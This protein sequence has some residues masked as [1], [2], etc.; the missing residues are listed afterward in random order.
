[1]KVCFKREDT[2]K[3]LLELD[4]NEGVV[5]EVGYN[6][7]I[8]GKCELLFDNSRFRLDG[9]VVLVTGDFMISSV[10]GVKVM[11]TKISAKQQ[12]EY[13]WGLT[14]QRSHLSDEDEWLYKMSRG[15]F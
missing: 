10:K 3:V 7:F 9:N 6:S 8:V 2:G 15:R 13:L 12:M 5:F 1:M 4:I 11:K 14:S